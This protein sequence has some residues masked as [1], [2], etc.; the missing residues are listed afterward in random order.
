[1][2]NI[3]A[4]L[5]SQVT[6]LFKLDASRF[7]RRVV[8]IAAKHLSAHTPS[9]QL[10]FIKNLFLNDLYLAQSCALPDESAWEEFAQQHFSFIKKFAVH[11]VKSPADAQEVADDVIAALWEKKKIG[12]FEGLSSLRTWLGT[13]IARNAINR[14]KRIKETLSL[15]STQFKEWQKQ[16]TQEPQSNAP[17]RKEVLNTIKSCLLELPEPDRI[18]LK[19]YYQQ[20]LK[21][22][23]MTS[24]Y[25]V[26]EATLSRQ[27][28]NLRT[29]I[30]NDVRGRLQK[31]L[32]IR[33]DEA[34]GMIS[35]TTDLDLDLQTLLEGASKF[36]TLN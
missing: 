34:R 26:S 4:F 5:Q 14:M 21:L 27:L 6:F 16:Q 11:C 9:D 17:M 32:N 28:K 36:G 10:S 35:D 13:V 20:G 31:D 3:S 1:M 22:R 25:R 33:F 8:E 2:D 18:F 19:L 7:M 30:A 29:R 24:L 23:E 15:G 12:M